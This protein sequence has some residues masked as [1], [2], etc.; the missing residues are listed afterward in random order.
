MCPLKPAQP[1][2]STFVASLWSFNTY[3]D[4]REYGVEL[5]YKFGS[6]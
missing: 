4:P 1:L 3:T 5:M 2:Y 6:K